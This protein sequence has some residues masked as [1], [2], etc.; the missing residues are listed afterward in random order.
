[1]LRLCSGSAQVKTAV[2]HVRRLKEPARGKIN[3]ESMGIRRFIS[4]ARRGLD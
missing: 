3:P 2:A 4:R 1:M